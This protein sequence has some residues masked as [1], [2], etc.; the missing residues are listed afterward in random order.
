MYTRQ[1]Y[2]FYYEF[3]ESIPLQTTRAET[4]IIVAIRTQIAYI[5]ML[6]SVIQEFEVPMSVC[7]VTLNQIGDNI[8]VT[9]I[10]LYIGDVI[11]VQ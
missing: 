5:G 9:E 8:D 11:T 1:F 6:V 7:I 10:Y 3:A 2:C 4:T